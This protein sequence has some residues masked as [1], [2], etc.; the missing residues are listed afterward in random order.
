MALTHRIND[1][2][3]E[4]DCPWRAERKAE[5]GLGAAHELNGDY[6]HALEHMRKVV[7]LSKEHR[8]SAGLS[9]AFGVIADIYTEM[10]NYGEAAVWYDRFLASVDNEEEEDMILEESE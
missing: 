10:G 6:A 4:L 2:G 7:D 8:D 1:A 3:N 5:R 9:D